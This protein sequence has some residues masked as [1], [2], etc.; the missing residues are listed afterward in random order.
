MDQIT[1]LNDAAAVRALSV[2]VREWSMARGFEVVAVMMHTRSVDSEKFAQAPA[3][4]TA[5]PQPSAEAGQFA[6]KMLKVLASNDDE[7]VM[8]WTERAV[9]KEW[10]E[11]K[12]VVAQVL[13]PITLSIVGVILIGAILAARVQKIGSAEFY[14]GIPKELASVIKV[15]ASFAA[16]TT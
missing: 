2:V 14:E 13:D 9:E 12:Q 7:Y 1:E 15:G 3:W 5:E 4:A 6:R 10:Q 11:Q 8:E 16:P